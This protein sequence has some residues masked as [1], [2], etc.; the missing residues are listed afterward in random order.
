MLMISKYMTHIIGLPDFSKMSTVEQEDFAIGDFIGY[1]M[2]KISEN[3]LKSMNLPNHNRNLESNDLC[4]W[5]IKV[6]IDNNLNDYEAYL[7][8]SV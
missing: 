3:G 6:V 1:D 4:V 7:Y 5:R 2:I 8:R